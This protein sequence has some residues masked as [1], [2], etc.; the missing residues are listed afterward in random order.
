MMVVK[1]E[2]WPK[3]DPQAAYSLGLASF[4]L[5]GLNEAGERTYRVLLHKM[6]RF[7]GP[8]HLKDPEGAVRTV[9]EA[10]EGQPRAVRT[11]WKAGRVAGHTPGT[12]GTWDLIGGALRGL[13]GR[14]LGPYH[15][16]V[17]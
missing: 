15:P 10:A 2:M 6:P 3:G 17:A 4:T 9:L 5:R 11:V 13:L 12:L 1:L 16:G 8:D 14:R 7:G